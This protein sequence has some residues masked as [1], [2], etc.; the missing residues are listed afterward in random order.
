[1][2]SQHPRTLLNRQ[3]VARPETASCP[4]CSSPDGRELTS[5][6]YVIYW[7]CDKCH[8]VW[9]ITKPETEPLIG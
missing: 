9:T 1:M 8:Y 2:S 3:P 5:T 6:T 4:F 7:G